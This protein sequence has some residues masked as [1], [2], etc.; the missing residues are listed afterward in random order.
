MQRILF[1]FFFSVT[2]YVVL[3]A[4]WTFWVCS[5]VV[6]ITARAI[7]SWHFCSHYPYCIWNNCSSGANDPLVT[8]RM[9]EGK[10]K[11]HQLFPALTI[12]NNMLWLNSVKLSDVTQFDVTWPN[13]A[14]HVP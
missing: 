12:R 9:D 14:C 6:T 4:T 10:R 7:F 3:I 1:F 5:L 11:S 8:H 2:Y 13:K